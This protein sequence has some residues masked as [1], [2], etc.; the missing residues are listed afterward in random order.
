MARAADA[1]AGVVTA[2][3]GVAML[4]P[5]L[6]LPFVGQ[7]N[8]PGAGLFPVVLSGTL[9]ALGVALLVTSLRGPSEIDAPVVAEEES[10]VPAGVRGLGRV[11][12]VWGG[13]AVAIIA[14]KYLGFLIS[15]FV[16]IVYLLLGP[17]HR[18]GPR[19]IATSLVTAVLLPVL[20]H[21][22]FTNVLGLTLPE[23]TLFGD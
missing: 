7:A 11:G 3:L 19:Q 23:G 13:F 12:A 18:R 1:V 22:L 17:S 16:L 14:M 21:L 6:R 2:A 10:T 9:G 15:V 4:V 5:A 8:A 20:A